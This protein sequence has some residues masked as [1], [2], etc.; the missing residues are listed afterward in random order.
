LSGC[1]AIDLLAAVAKLIHE[2]TRG[3]GLLGPLIVEAVCDKFLEH[4]PIE[5]QCARFARAGNA[6]DRKASG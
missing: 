3:P 2:Q 6:D 1:E 5:R 4:L